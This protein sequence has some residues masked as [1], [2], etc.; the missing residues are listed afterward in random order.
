MVQK[1]ITKYLASHR[2]KMKH[3]KLWILTICLIGVDMASKHIFYNLRYWDDIQWVL[4][5][6]NKGIS[7]SLP[8]PYVIII[9]ISILGIGGFIRLFVKKQ[10]SWV[11][12]GVLIAGTA[13]NLIDRFVYGWVR[14]FIDIGLFNFPIFNGADMMLS[15]GIAIW[16]IRVMLEKKK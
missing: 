14:D 15:L 10:I 6:L 8:L 4:P 3:I 16:I 9:S 7:R 11:I 1:N 2:Q 5:V 13:G 12:G